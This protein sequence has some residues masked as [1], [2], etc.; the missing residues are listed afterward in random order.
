MN[1][2]S[3]CSCSLS[4]AEEAAEG[5][6]RASWSPNVGDGAFNSLVASL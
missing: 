2:N 1:E 3:C 6:W 4:E 5:C